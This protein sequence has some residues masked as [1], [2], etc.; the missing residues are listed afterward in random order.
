[1]GRGRKHLV[2]SLEGRGTRYHLPLFVV[3]G[4]LAIYSLSQTSLVIG[5][6]IFATSGSGKIYKDNAGTG[7]NFELIGNTPVVFNDLA[8]NGV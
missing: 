6:S 4:L 7:A 1:M 3:I 8:Y 5:G 2:W